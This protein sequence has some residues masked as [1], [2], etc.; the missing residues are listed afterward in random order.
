MASAA[1]PTPARKEREWSGVETPPRRLYI[2]SGASLDT[3]PRDLSPWNSYGGIPLTGHPAVATE[4]PA[5]A[6]VWR[7]LGELLYEESARYSVIIYQWH[8]ARAGPAFRI[9]PGIPIAG[10]AGS[11]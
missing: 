11:L 8:I 1:K 3:R 4:F 10:T 5:P 7:G 9:L 6:R 2:S